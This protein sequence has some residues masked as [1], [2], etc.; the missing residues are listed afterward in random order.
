MPRALVVGNG[1]MLINFDSQLNMR[2]LYYPVVG[3]DNHIGGQRCSTG[4]WEGG[5]FSWLWEDDWQK[6]LGYQEDSL[7]TFVQA[8]NEKMGLDVQINDGV[9]PHFNIFVRKMTIKNL[10]NWPRRMRIFFNHDFSISE[11]NIGDT[12]LFDP[13]SRGICHYK[14]DI[15]LLANGAAQGRGIFQY[16]TGR[17]R[18]LGAEGTWRDA[19]DGWLGGN[20]IDHGS[21]D[22]TI[23]FEINLEAREEENLWYWIALGD[24]L[25]A[26]RELDNLV[27]DHGPGYLLQETMDYCRNWVNRHDWNFGDLPE[28][29]SK[30]FKQSLLIVRTHCDNN[31]AILAATDSDILATARDT[32]NYIWPRDAAL[33][34]VALDRVGFPEIPVRFFRLSAQ[35]ITDGG[36][37]LQ[38][39]NPDGSPGS[40]WYPLIRDGREQL[41]IQEDETAL[42]SCALWHHYRQCHDFEEMAPFYWNLAKKMGDFLLQ[43]RDPQTGLPLSSYDLWEERWGV[44]SFTAASVH[45]GLMAAANLG[46]LFGDTRSAEHY[47]Q[48]AEEVR[49]GMERY[50]YHEKVGRFLRGIYYRQRE[51]KMEP[52]PDFTLDSSLYGLFGFGVFPADDPRVERTM[53]AVE[54]GLRVNTWVGGLARYTADW[55]YRMSD[56]IENVPGS[57]WIITTLW[58]AE[59]YAAKAKTKEELAQA[60]SILEWAADRAME[61]GILAE[62]FHPYTGEPLSVAPLTWSHSTFILAVANYIDKW[63]MTG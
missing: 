4:F 16:A 18:F 10:R 29:V 9:H 54:E 40:G 51:G 2:D 6:K 45:A 7:V 43:F 61:S 37:N 44:F 22:S 27:R 26:V 62:Q 46:D 15:Y 52:I 42:V 31:G 33:V 38:R 58:L 36:Y 19:E 14:R 35:M 8:I 49:E 11:N 28:K 59:W 34:A 63:Q 21:V 48:G 47:R 17:K 25:E 13:V 60:R 12:A 41:P 30:L 50:L 57:P 1:N 53:K 24:R 3:M 5:H 32:Y 55:Y 56:D 23:S 39:Y 20:P